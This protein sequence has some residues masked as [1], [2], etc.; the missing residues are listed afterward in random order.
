[1]GQLLDDNRLLVALDVDSAQRAL[2]LARSLRDVAGGF[3]VGSRLFTL[4]G[5]S[6]VRQLADSG[7]K[8][9]LDLKFHDIPN[10][11]SR[12]A[13]E[14]MKLGVDMLNLH[15]SGGM[16]M[17]RETADRCRKLAEKLNRPKPILLAVTIL[18]SMGEEDLREIGLPGSPVDNVARLAKLSHASG[19]DGV[20]C[21]PQEVTMLRSV[22]PSNFSLVTPGID[23]PV[24]EIS[25]DPKTVRLS[26]S[27]SPLGYR[28]TA[29][30]SWISTD[31]TVKLSVPWA[32]S[33]RRA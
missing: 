4:E 13:E 19:M 15:A 1:M 12:A 14:A 11:V 23:V 31:G 17:M 24:R 29:T 18:T 22:L 30:T 25:S 21:S 26:I 10:T 3:K 20:V 5:P 7:V 8:V 33:N 28:S 16:E 9:F 32:S 6:L 27:F 2:A